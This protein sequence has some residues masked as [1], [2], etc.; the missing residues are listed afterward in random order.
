MDWQPCEFTARD[1]ASVRLSLPPGWWALPL[2]GDDLADQVRR[3]TDANIPAE[4]QP[5]VR[6]ELSAEW[7]RLARAAATAAAVL[8]AGGAAY[9]EDAD[10]IV[11]ASLTVVPLRLYDLAADP[12]EDGPVGPAEVLRLPAGAAVRG[13]RLGRSPSPVGDVLQLHVEYRVADAWMLAFSTPALHHVEQLL[14]AFDAI[15]ATLQLPVSDA[16]PFS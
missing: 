6:S 5:S 10:Q 11:T 1:G 9:D 7:Q 4:A 2:I 14:P 13:V 15:A 12:D 8:L 3:F 16:A